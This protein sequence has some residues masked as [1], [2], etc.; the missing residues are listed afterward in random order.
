MLKKTGIIVAVTTAGLLVVSP[1]A[2]AHGGDHHHSDHRD[3]D[4]RDGN[5]QH[6]LIN[7]QNTNAQVPLQMCD[8]SVVEG[9]LGILARNERN[10]DSH[11]GTCRQHN[12]ADNGGRG[13][14]DRDRH[15]H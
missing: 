14:H 15:D 11:R 2:F 9:V 7:L 8:N 6:G 4:H 10:R 3:S 5:Y 13:H 1:L 12:D